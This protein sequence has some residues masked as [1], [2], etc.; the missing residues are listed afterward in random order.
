MASGKFLNSKTVNLITRA[1]LNI[2]KNALSLAQMKLYIKC[3]LFS[4]YF[5]FL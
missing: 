2:F 1:N 4:D 5:F 3:L